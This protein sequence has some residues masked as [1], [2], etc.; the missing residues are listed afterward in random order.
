MRIK[1]KKNGK[2]L[3]VEF[4]FDGDLVIL[5]LLDKKEREILVTELLRAADDILSGIT[6]E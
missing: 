4:N 1:T 5:G 3:D 2:Y 6:D